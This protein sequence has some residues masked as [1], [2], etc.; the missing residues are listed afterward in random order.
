MKELSWINWVKVICMVFVYFFH[1]REYTHADD[2]GL[3]NFYGAFF[4]NA[5]FFASGYLLFAKQVGTSVINE[6]ASLFVK[7]GG[8]GYKAL[9][10]VLNKLILPTILFTTVNYFPKKILRG[11]GIDFMSFAHDTV[12]GGSTWFT[13]ALA[14]AELVLILLL[15]TRINKMWFYGLVSSALAISA[16]ILAQNNVTIWE[17]LVLPWYYKGGMVCS[18]ILMGGGIFGGMRATSP[19]Y[20]QEKGECWHM[21]CCY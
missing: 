15:T 18:L 19:K 5:F 6:S 4:T 14:V 8:A 17:S 3:V 20:Q 11:E 9:I 10:G 12:L 13:S 2:L 1:V 16:I 21:L 7:A